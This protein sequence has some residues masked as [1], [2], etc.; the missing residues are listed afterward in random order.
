MAWLV[1]F[2]FLIITKEDVL[3]VDV[4]K[5]LPPKK[6][7]DILGCVLWPIHCLY[8]HHKCFLNICFWNHFFMFK[9]ILVRNWNICFL[10]SLLI[11]MF[12]ILDNTVFLSSFI[13]VLTNCSI[14]EIFCFIIWWKYISLLLILINLKCS[15]QS[16]KPNG[17]SLFHQARPIC[18]TYLPWWTKPPTNQTNWMIVLCIVQ[19]T[20]KISICLTMS[21]MESYFW[22][23]QN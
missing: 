9:F 6:K 8:I 23:Y 4:S 11:W 12:L 16:F 18:C 15:S 20:G 14:R 19:S 5:S 22:T 10:P 7:R 1:D 3:E 13:C 2:F 21:N 17:S